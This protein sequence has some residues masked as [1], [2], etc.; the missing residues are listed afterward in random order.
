MCLGMAGSVLNWPAT[1][2]QVYAAAT[3]GITDFGSPHLYSGSFS[4]NL[5]TGAAVT[6]ELPSRISKLN[7]HGA[8]MSVAWVLLLP[9]GTLAA[10]HR[11]VFGETRVFG[12]HLWFRLHVALQLSGMVC[13]IVGFV[14]AWK[15]LPGVGNGDPTGAKV[16]LAHMYLG[17]I[18][19]GLAGL[20]VIVGFVRPKPGS[21]PRPLWNILHHWLGRLTIVSAWATVYT[22]IYMAH[23]SLAY[24]AS[25]TT[26]LLPIA[27]IMGVIILADL[28]LSAYN[29]GY[30]HASLSIATV[31]PSI[32]MSSQLA[33][34]NNGAIPKGGRVVKVEAQLIGSDPLGI[35]LGAND[36]KVSIV[37]HPT[38]AG[39]H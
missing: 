37:S 6:T 28:L 38:R 30:N 23:T 36:A 11:W 25:Y 29:F 26:W 18:I 4:V 27:V 34:D 5:G 8:L 16:G 21:R 10:R 22:G 17:T 19:M 9:L 31:H 2:F 14:Y 1:F 7:I 15:Y 33:G 24:Q 32:G 35:G 13:F 12:L 3:D 20:Q 39:I